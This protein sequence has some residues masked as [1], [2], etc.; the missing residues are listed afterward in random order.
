[1]NFIFESRIKNFRLKD[2]NKIENWLSSVI[3]KENKK[4][5]DIKYIFVDDREIYEINSKFLGHAY[6]TDI[7]T[8]DYSFLNTITGEIFISL[9]V[10]ESNAL[11]YNIDHSQE[12]Y[13]V[14]VHGLLHL[15][16]YNDKSDQE[17][18][19]MRDK[20]DFYLAML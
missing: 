5:G 15:I 19:A 1:L 3:Q 2:S 6:S 8:F 20:E 9:P 12:L 13:R 16:G 11:F 4:L 17:K 14:I 10:V 7:I 18:E